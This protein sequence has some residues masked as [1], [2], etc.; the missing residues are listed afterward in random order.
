MGERTHRNAW[1]RQEIEGRAPAAVSIKRDAV[2]RRL[3]RRQRQAFEKAAGALDCVRFRRENPQPFAANTANLS[4]QWRQA[5]V[6]IVG[7]QAETIFGAA[8]EHAI[9]LRDATGHEVIDHY[10][11]IRVCPRHDEVGRP[12]TRLQRSVHARDKTLAR[13]LFIPGRAVDLPSQE[14]PRKP[15]HFQRRVQLPRIDVVILDRIAGPDHGSVLQAWDRLQKGA[16][17]VFRQRG[18][19]AVR[20]D[21]VIVQALGLEKDLMASAILEADDLVLDGWAVARPDALDLAGVHRR[22]MDVRR[23]DR[24]RLLASWL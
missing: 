17:N 5:L 2:S 20:I 7:A 18:R 1:Q 6:S 19:D 4:G 22:A 9:G 10:S 24:V 12:A 21:G 23:N 16:L 15:L 8:R 14:Q 11:D 3:V 13:C